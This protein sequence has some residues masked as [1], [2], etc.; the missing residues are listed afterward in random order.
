ME[1]EKLQERIVNF[2]RKRTELHNKKITAELSYIHLMEE[3]GEIARQL[4]SKD[5]RPEK[6][7]EDNLKEE[8][9][10]VILECLILADV[11]DVDLETQLTNKINALYAK[12]NIPE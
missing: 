11:L 2:A 5:I 10:D 7:D 6:Y 9:V 8:I 4:F 12:H 1:L 3:M